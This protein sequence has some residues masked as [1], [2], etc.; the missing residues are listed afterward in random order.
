MTLRAYWSG[1]LQVGLLA[2]MLEALRPGLEQ[3]RRQAR[4]GV[5]VLC[6]TPF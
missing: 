4:K 1:S 2:D 3:A 5:A 6:W